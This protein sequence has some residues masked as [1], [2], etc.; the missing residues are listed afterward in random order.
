M[1]AVRLRFSELHKI[2]VRSKCCN[3]SGQVGDVEKAFPDVWKGLRR[4]TIG[5][6]QGGRESMFRIAATKR[7]A[8]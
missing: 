8:M 7:C 1:L 3:L 5:L 2:A 6:E 4:A